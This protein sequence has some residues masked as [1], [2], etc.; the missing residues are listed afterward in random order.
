MKT[1]E[2]DK[3]LDKYYRGETTLEE[4]N[5]LKNEILQDE[6]ETSENDI[7]SFFREESS[8]PE[9]LER[10]IFNKIKE[11]APLRKVIKMRWFRAASVAATV[12]ILL[13]AYLG[14]RDIRNAKIENEFLV[15]EHALYQVSQSIQ[16]EEQEDMLV[17]WVDED[18]QIIIN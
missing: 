8:V 6:D 17:L 7:F 15:M 11:P 9:N 1:E 4:E 16:P 2:K 10:Q 12:V 18:V 5:E 14:Y 13:T 3:L